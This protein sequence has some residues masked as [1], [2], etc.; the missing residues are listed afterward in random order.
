[1]PHELRRQEE[2][3]NAL[4][5]RV[6]ARVM[7]EDRVDC[8]FL[9]LP[10]PSEEAPAFSTGNAASPPLPISAQEGTERQDCLSLLQALTAAKAALGREYGQLARRTTGSVCQ[11][12]SALA[13][14]ERNHA[15][16]LA[17]ACFLLS[18]VRPVPP[19]PAAAASRRVRPPLP[20]A[21]RRLFWWE[22]Q[23][24]TM[25]AAAMGLA[26]EETLGEL[27]EEMARADG[28]HRRT[29]RRLVERL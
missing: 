4:F 25:L 17:A 9:V 24:Q 29:L 2:D 21:L 22:G 14:E 11:S 20:A 19:A 27:L 13:A 8:P 23:C 28:R 18:G 10:P 6:W 15:R 12:L 1:M 3:P 26:E 5:R 16:R 7:P